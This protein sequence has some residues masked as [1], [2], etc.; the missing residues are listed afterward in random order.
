MAT[1]MREERRTRQQVE[2]RKRN[3]N[4]FEREGIVM[5]DWCGGGR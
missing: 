1:W 4:R 5:M 2:G 3:R